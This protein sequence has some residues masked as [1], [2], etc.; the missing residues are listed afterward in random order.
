[1]V[2]KTATT[3]K[4]T[5]GAKSDPRRQITTRRRGAAE[6]IGT[7]KPSEGGMSKLWKIISEPEVEKAARVHILILE[8]YILKA[9]P[10]DLNQEWTS[11]GI[12]S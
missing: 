5:K 11:Q 6:S 10:R 7:R 12:E 3:V 4:T 2:K 1:M 8:V 9:N